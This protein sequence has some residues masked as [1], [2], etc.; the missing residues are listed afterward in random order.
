MSDREDTQAG[1]GDRDSIRFPTI[2]EAKRKYNDLATSREASSGAYERWKKDTDDQKQQEEASMEKSFGHLSP[3]SR[4][5]SISQHQAI[6]NAEI[7]LNME[8]QYWKTSVGSITFEDPNEGSKTVIIPGVKPNVGPQVAFLS[9]TL[10][11]KTPEQLGWLDEKAESPEDDSTLDRCIK[12][13]S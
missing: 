9:K 3:E 5:R 11:L 12:G 2:S 8:R 1:V 10:D 4:R 7:Q 13:D 6:K